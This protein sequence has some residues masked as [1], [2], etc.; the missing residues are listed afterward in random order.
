MSLNPL[1]IRP[2]TEADWPF[3]LALF[4][5]VAGRGEAYAYDEHTTEATVRKLWFD[6]PA[7]PFIAE[8]HGKCAG[9]Y[10]IRPNQPGRGAHVAN[11]GY[12]V[13]PAFEGLGITSAMCQHSIEAA[14]VAGYRAMQFNF[15][16][17]TNEAALHVWK[18]HGFQVLAQ[19]P[20]VF[21]HK[22]LGYVDACVLWRSL[23]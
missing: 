5:D 16:I 20:E 21:L 10:Y 12:M 2:A 7:Q 18:K 4:M 13:P 22:N 14:Q 23:V 1:Q 3:I 19:L 6:A 9:T 11:G 8:W 15:V 17:A